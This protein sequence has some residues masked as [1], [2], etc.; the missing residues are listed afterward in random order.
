MRD[1]IFFFLELHRVRRDNRELQLRGRIA[2]KPDGGFVARTPGPL[3]IEIEAVREEM[4]KLFCGSLSLGSF[5][6]AEKCLDLALGTAGN[7]DKP[8]CPLSREPRFLHFTPALYMTLVFEPG[9][10]EQ[11]TERMVA[12]MIHAVDRETEGMSGILFVRDPEITAKDRLD[13]L[14]VAGLIETDASE[15]VHQVRL[16]ECADAPL[17]HLLDGGVKPDDTVRNRIFGMKTEM[18]EFWL[19]GDVGIKRRRD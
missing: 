13:A 1:E 15:H 10:R 12:V 6:P 17:F 3:Q 7:T 4:S 19:H 18:N 9:P 8:L 2:E 14:L 5:S 11:H 16:P